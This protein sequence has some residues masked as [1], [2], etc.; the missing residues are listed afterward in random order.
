MI[1]GSR[2]QPN[3]AHAYWTLA[4]NN[5][6]A[7]RQCS[8]AAKIDFHYLNNL[9]RCVF[10]G[11]RTTPLASISHLYSE[12]SN[13]QDIERRAEMLYRC[14]VHR[15]HTDLF[16]DRIY[17]FVVVVGRLAGRL[18]LTACETIAMIFDN[19]YI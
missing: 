7:I 10:T 6:S 2:N 8:V 18:M 13:S 1:R 5:E 9:W 14:Y 3:E 16:C 15:A 11:K 17:L 19:E 12:R 4:E